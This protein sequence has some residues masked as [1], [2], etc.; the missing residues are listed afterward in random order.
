VDFLSRQV[1]FSDGRTAVV[2]LDADLD[3]HREACA[4]LKWLQHGA[5][6]SPGT[7]RT[8]GSRIAAY[9]S[10]ADQ[11]G[12]DWR[13]PALDQLADLVRWLHRGGQGMQITPRSPGYVNL[14]LSAIGGFLRFCALHG[15]V[16]TEV[17]DR[18][19][20]P[21]FLRHLP[22]GFDPGES[23]NRVVR[24]SMLRMKTPIRPPRFLSVDQQ[25]SIVTSTRNLRDRFLVEMLFGTGLRVGEACGLH[26]ADMHFL[27]SSQSL[28]CRFPG[29][30]LH[31][32]RRENNV[33]GALAKSLVSRAVPV[34]GHLARLYADYRQHRWEQLGDADVGDFVFVNLYRPPLG[35]PMRPDA[36]EDL[37]ERLSEDAGVKA[38]PHTC[39]HTF[40]TRMVRAGVDRDVV[41]S[42]L[43]HAS[44]MSTAVYTHADW[45]DLRSAVD[46]TA[47]QQVQS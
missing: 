11:S 31:V 26:R 46:L 25:A 24:R 16:P 47:R 27:P 4:Y 5:G 35:C 18:L 38:T 44:P 30:H 36:V 29:P 7:A 34:T 2:V 6:R 8:Y 40:A 22:A 32:H 45:S 1:R 3:P 42:L 37:F 33:N 17:A 13:T 15:A 10:W 20:E 14:G 12:I 39:R 9:L 21:R 28:G 19:S 43:G 23:G 41:Q